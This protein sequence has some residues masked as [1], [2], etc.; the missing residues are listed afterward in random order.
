[1]RA[2][3][4]RVFDPDILDRF[5]AIVESLPAPMAFPTPPN[6]TPTKPIASPFAA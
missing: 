2:D 4:G 3:R 1:M 5:T 6:D